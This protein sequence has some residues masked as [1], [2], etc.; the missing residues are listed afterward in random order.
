MS[1]LT[2]AVRVPYNVILRYAPSKL[3]MFLWD[4]EFASGKWNF[5]DDTA[6]DCVYQY[7]SRYARQGSVLDLGCGP[8]NTANEMAADSYMIYEGVDVSEIALEKARQRSD[9]NGRSRKNH[10]VRADLL[11]HRPVRQFDVILLRESLYHVPLRQ[12]KEVF[13]HYAPY[14]KNGGVFIVRIITHNRRGTKARLR[15]IETEFSI[16]DKGEHGA[17]GLTVI[18]FQPKPQRRVAA[19]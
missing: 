17:D 6:D 1:I 18:V 10:F 8:G 7:V 4:R 9:T 11:T 3:K 2:R 15:V 19:G 14:L 12:T 5:I 16:I 13:D